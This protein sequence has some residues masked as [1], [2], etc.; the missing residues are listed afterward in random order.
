MSRPPLLPLTLAACLLLLPACD[1]DASDRAPDDT[2]AGVATLPRPEANGGSVTGFDGDAPPPQPPP[3]SADAGDAVV[4]DPEAPVANLPGDDPDFALEVPPVAG[5]EP[6]GMPPPSTAAT[7]PA[8]AAPAEPGAAEAAAVVRNY[9]GAINAGQHARA[10]GMWSD[11]G[12]ASGQ[13]A[14]QFARGFGDTTRVSVSTGE[15]GRVEGAAGSRYV[16]IPVAVEAVHADGSVHHYDGSYT[17]RRA[18][19]DGATAEQRQWRI[20]DADLREVE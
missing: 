9:Y 2:A 8:P 18:V 4:A 10:Y 14:D 5:S 17:L 6:E 19:V 7:N 11:G 3:A 16:T 1:R 13:T 15:P 20:S 12:R